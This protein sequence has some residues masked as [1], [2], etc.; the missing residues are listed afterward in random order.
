MVEIL[1]LLAMLHSHPHINVVLCHILL[2]LHP[3]ELWTFASIGIP[4]MEGISASV[5]IWCAFFDVF[6]CKKCRQVS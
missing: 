6:N 4:N 1:L 3:A 5:T 2:I